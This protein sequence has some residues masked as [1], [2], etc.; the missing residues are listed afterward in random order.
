VTGDGETQK[1]YGLSMSANAV[2]I[3]IL[4]FGGFA[5]FAAQQFAQVPGAALRCIAGTH[6]EA[7]LACAARF[8]LADVERAEVLFA[9]PD[10]QLVY[11]ATPPFLHHEQARDALRAGKHVIVEKP[12]A[13]TMPQADE[14]VSIARE[15]R[16][17]VV[18]NLM[19]R[20]NPLF[21]QIKQ[22]VD[23]KLLG[24]VL[25]GTFENYASDEG[26][27]PNHWFWDP[28]KSGGI[29]IEHGVHFFDV[30]AGWLGGGSVESAGRVLRPGSGIEEQVYCTARYGDVPVTFYHGFTQAGRMDRQELRLLFE[31]GD[32]TLREW[33]PTQ[34][35]VRTA[36]DEAATRALASI[37]PGARIDVENLYAPAERALRARHKTYEA[38]QRITL[39]SAPAM[40]M[41]VYGDLLRAM[42]SDQLAYIAEPSHARV[43]TED[44]GRES[45]RMSVQATQLAT[46]S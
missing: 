41:T 11:I 5:M 9:M 24:E 14:L 27:G 21:G 8:G 32:V 28:T 39:T 12:L 17:L 10:V 20:Y 38:Y 13:V 36:L 43:I 40:K 31:R 34:A 35:V 29:F 22:L 46:A 44:N 30:F 37:F 1:G 7:S 33:I 6:R 3:G 26:L 4:G 25:H 45:L 42:L 15:Q 2:G 18:T 23:S 16:L 19:Q